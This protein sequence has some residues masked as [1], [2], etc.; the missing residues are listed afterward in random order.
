MGYTATAQLLGSNYSSLHIK[1]GQELFKNMSVLIVMPQYT[2]TTTLPGA[3][4]EKGI[5]MKCYK[6]AASFPP[7][8]TQS[9]SPGISPNQTFYLEN[10]SHFNTCYPTEIICYLFLI[11][12]TIQQQ[13]SGLIYKY[14]SA[15]DNL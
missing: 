2:V 6:L 1:L 3:T 12:S 5:K 10:P 8:Q 9:M 15:T 11:H 4:L 13:E 7:G 14:T